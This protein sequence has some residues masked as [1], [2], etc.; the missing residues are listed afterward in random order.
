MKEF[1]AFITKFYYVICESLPL[2]KIFIM[3]QSLQRL[4]DQDP[5]VSLRIE[6]SSE[7]F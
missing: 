7:I 2:I 6:Q 4:L 1:F 3:E 5:E